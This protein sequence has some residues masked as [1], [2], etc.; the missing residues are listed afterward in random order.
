[1]SDTSQSPFDEVRDLVYRL[2]YPP[3]KGAY[4]IKVDDVMKAIHT[5]VRELMEGIIGEDDTYRRN[6]TIRSVMEIR[7]KL[8]AEQR[9][10]LLAALSPVGGDMGG[11]G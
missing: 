4:Q 1:M 10:A 8:R 9:A 5:A 6:Y 2:K 7:N 11:E 3:S